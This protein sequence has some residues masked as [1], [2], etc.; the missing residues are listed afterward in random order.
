MGWLDK[1]VMGA[2]EAVAE[3][4]SDAIELPGKIMDRIIDGKE[5]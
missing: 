1:L 3:T 4:A 2:V 5:K